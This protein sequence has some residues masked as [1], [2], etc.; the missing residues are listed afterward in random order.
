MQG[1]WLSVLI[2]ETGCAERVGG[3]SYTS[4]DSTPGNDDDIYDEVIED[5]SIL[6]GWN[7]PS[8]F[9]CELTRFT[10]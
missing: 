5:R 10:R 6:A 7:L 8:D 1:Q 9:S 3:Y 2:R 4:P